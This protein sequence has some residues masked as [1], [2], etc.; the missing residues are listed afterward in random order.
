MSLKKIVNIGFPMFVLVFCCFG[1]FFAPNDPHCVDISNRLAHRCYRYPLGT[2]I[3]GRCTL[4]RLLYGGRTTVGIV[5]LSCLC[6][7]VSGMVIGLLISRSKNRRE[8]LFES[9]LNAVT[10]IPP[11]SYLIIFIAAWGNCILTMLVSISLSLFLRLIKLVKTRAEIEMNCAYVLCAVTS[12]AGRLRVLFWHILPNLISDVVR[13][14][15]LS[16]ADMV[17]AIVGFSFIGLGLG[18]NIIDWGSMI[19][20]SN[21]MMLSHPALMFY[22]VVFIFLSTLSFHLLGRVASKGGDYYA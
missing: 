8:I 22:P 13:F 17:L 14:I 19:S 2:D 11:I 21:Q 20:D 5:S 15:C 9:I 18:D 12:G 1:H 4:S 6:V 7:A 16:C 3:L 10:A